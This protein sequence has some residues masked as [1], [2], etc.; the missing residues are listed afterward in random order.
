MSRRVK[1]TW[2][3]LV[4]GDA[5]T[6]PFHDGMTSL[7]VVLDKDFGIY[8]AVMGG[9]FEDGVDPDEFVKTADVLLVGRTTDE[10]FYHGQWKVVGKVEAP[11]APYPC[12]VV[13]TSEGEVLKDFKGRVLRAACPGDMEKYGRKLNVPNSEFISALKAIHG[14]GDAGVDYSAIDVAQAG[15]KADS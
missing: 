2:K 1:T 15:I 5:F 4:R 9:I 6:I 3:T 7:G 10:M 8:I 12:Y 11:D 14:V 13:D